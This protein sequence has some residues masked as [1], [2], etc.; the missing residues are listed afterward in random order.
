MAKKGFCPKCHRITYLTNHHIYPKRFY[1]NSPIFKLCR[2]CHDALEL[3]IPF[4][5]LKD[6]DGYIM[7]MV[8]FLKS[9]GGLYIPQEE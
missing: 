5:K 7:I 4:R 2:I 1:R 9:D 8:E 6:K 3:K